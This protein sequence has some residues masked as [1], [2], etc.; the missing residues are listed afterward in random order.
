MEKMPAT[1][2]IS[3]LVGGLE[4]FLFFHILGTIIPI[5]FHI[6]QMGWNHQPEMTVCINLGSLEPLVKWTC[7]RPP[8]IPL[9]AEIGDSS[10]VISANF[11]LIYIIPGCTGNFFSWGSST[12]NK[13]FG[14]D[15]NVKK[16]SHHGRWKVRGQENNCGSQENHTRII[17]LCD[18]IST[19]LGTCLPG[20]HGFQ[21]KVGVQENNF[22]TNPRNRGG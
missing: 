13:N 18:R 3:Y 8:F 22:W 19:I 9:G 4:H 17:R 16:S 21:N 20:A 1:A 6:F 15:P 7:F 12:K 11:F 5:D 10:K 14:V 2:L